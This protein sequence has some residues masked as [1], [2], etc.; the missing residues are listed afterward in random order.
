[1]LAKE[2][3]IMLV[4]PT[5]RDLRFLKDWGDKLSGCHLLVIEDAPVK[6]ID[7]PIKFFKSISHYSWEEI[8]RDL[9]K[10]SWII[11]RRNAGIRSYGFWK[12][13]KLG[14]DI[15]MTIDDDCF[16][17][18]DDF[19]SGH[20]DN[21][22]FKGPE[23]WL[24]TYPDPKWMYSR[25]I[26][27]KVRNKVKMGISHGIWSGALDLDGDTESRLPNLLKEKPYAPIRQVIPFNYYYPMCSM[28]L[29][30]TREITPLMFFP[31]MGESPIGKKWPYDR[32]DDI[33]AGIFSKKIM[34]HLEIGVVN[35]SPIVQHKKASK[36]KENRAKEMSGLKLNEMLWER[37]D[38]IKLTAKTPKACYI[39]M[40]QNIDFPKNSY[41]NKLK[42]AMIIWAKLF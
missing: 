22:N 26:P 39:E 5:I 3:K 12:A 19:V 30:F 29:A 28:N 32:Y 2:S 7:I 33:W 23:K 41:F 1:M 8:D 25:G 15:I 18:N 6:S 42:E 36:P 40:A 14:A 24:N 4:I 20:L 31:M 9:G 11:S 17:T 34:D 35:G 38:A 27:N 13:F 16:P 21:L 37:A 10:N